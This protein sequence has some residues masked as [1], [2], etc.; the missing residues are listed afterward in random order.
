M[1]ERLDAL[2]ELNQGRAD[3]AAG[4]L[5]QAA[6]TLAGLQEG[7]AT[8]IAAV[9]KLERHLSLAQGILRAKSW[10]HP[11]LTMSEQLTLVLT[12]ELAMGVIFELPLV[13]A[14]LASLG[15]VKARFLMKYQRHA[16]VVCLIIAAIVT[17]TGDAVNL[18]L[19]AGP[20]VLCYELGVLAAWLVEKR[21]AGEDAQAVLPAA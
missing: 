18:S 6:G 19:M 17:P 5:D 8:G 10:T 4:L 16:F 7:Y 13:M 20:M 11:M 9:W 2:R 21:R 15:L 12:L 14:L 1:K 3:K